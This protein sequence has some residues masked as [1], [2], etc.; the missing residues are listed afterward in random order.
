MIPIPVK[1]I[2]I[3]HI[4][5][6]FAAFPQI[7]VAVLFGSRATKDAH[8]FS[9]YDFAIVADVDG[10]EFGR[11]W[12]ELAHRLGVGEDDIDLVDLK[13]ASRGLKNSIKENYILLKGSEVELARLLE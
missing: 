13:R 11:L 2:E 1:K 5:E 9:D 10:W 8:R 12:V 4:K 7:S 6:V 3:S